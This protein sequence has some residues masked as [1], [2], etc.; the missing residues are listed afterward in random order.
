[1]ELGREL[2]IDWGYRRCSELVWVK[3]NQLQSL[4]RTGRT[5]HFLNHGKEHCLVGIKGD[6]AKLKPLTSP[7]ATGGGMRSIDCDVIVSE[8]QETS[9]KPEAV[10]GV[11][12]RLA[13]GVRKVELFGRRHNTGHPGWITLGNQLG[14]SKVVD[15]KLAARV[16]ARYPTMQL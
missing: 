4:I 7:E 14:D 8:V 12:E 13:P 16:H 10:Y 9:R 6:A 15:M 11:I 3:I 2:L 1:M 5:G